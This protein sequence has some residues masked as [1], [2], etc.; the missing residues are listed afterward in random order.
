MILMVIVN[1][2]PVDNTVSG[3][4]VRFAG[5]AK[6]TSTTTAGFVIELATRSNNSSKVADAG[7]KDT[8]GVSV[9]KQYVYL[10]N[11]ALGTLALGKV[12]QPTSGVANISLAGNGPDCRL[13]R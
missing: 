7:E 11:A 2:I 10:K 9:D 3:T 8:G 6:M 4:E 5:S 13:C 1:F 12:G